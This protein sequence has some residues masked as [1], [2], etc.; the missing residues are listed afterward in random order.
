MHV[1]FAPSTRTLPLSLER[2]E[3]LS[4]QI[5]D[6]FSREIG[7]PLKQVT[8]QANSG[9]LELRDL[10]DEYGHEATELNIIYA[11]RIA[12]HMTILEGIGM[13][14]GA[15]GERLDLWLHGDLADKTGIQVGELYNIAP[16]KSLTVVPAQIAGIW[17]PVDADDP[18]WMSDPDQTLGDK[19]LVRRDDYVSH[20]EPLLEPKVRSATWQIVLDE[21]AVVP[22]NVRHY[23]DGYTRAEI[24]VR[25]FLPDVQITTPTVSLGEFVDRQT[26]L[27][28]LAA[29]LQ[30]PG[31]RVSCSI[32]SCSR[33]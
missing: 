24:I 6:R 30:Y 2:V 28:T 16:S 32:S 1:L 31:A 33:R 4:A 3:N 21:D 15:S 29:R 26:S 5:A 17:R 22:A 13:E 14:D 25:S 23:I 12:E 10:D 11:D 7:L 27:T 9:K 8:L 18:Y 20:L 19:M